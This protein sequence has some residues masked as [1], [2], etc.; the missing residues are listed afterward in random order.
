MMEDGG[1]NLGGGRVSGGSARRNVRA[2]KRPEGRAPETEDRR[3]K[4]EHGT[5]V[6]K[7]AVNAPQSKRFAKFGGVRWQRAGV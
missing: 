7:A 5:W 6:A 1:W 2:L 4:M 3:W